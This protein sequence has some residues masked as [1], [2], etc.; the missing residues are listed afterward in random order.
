[1]KN[2][3]YYVR[4]NWNIKIIHVLEKILGS[5]RNIWIW[6]QILLNVSKNWEL[7]S[8]CP[9]TC[10]KSSFAFAIAEELF[11]LQTRGDKHEREWKTGRHRKERTNEIY[12]IERHIHLCIRKVEKTREKNTKKKIKTNRE[13]C[14]NSKEWERIKGWVERLFHL[15]NNCPLFCYFL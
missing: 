1:M 9:A 10:K 3:K 6:R 14:R 13:I 12:T 8:W 5:G 11:Y 15:N 4:L 7:F 2:I